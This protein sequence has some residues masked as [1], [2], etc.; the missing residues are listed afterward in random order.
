MFRG[1]QPYRLAPSF[2]FLRR[3]QM[4]IEHI[5]LVKPSEVVEELMD[6]VWQNTEKEIVATN[7][8]KLSRFRNNNR[9]V[10]FSWDEYVAF[11]SHR[12]T[13]SEQQ[14]LDDLAATGYLAKLGDKYVFTMRLLDVYAQYVHEPHSVS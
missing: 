14:I 8:L 2:N 1:K 11:C 12:A 4:V 7:I 9:W 5:S 3:S 13:L 10:P 6:T